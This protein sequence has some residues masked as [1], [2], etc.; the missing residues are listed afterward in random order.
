MARTLCLIGYALFIIVNGLQFI[1]S[2]KEYFMTQKTRMFVTLALT[3]VFGFL[4]VTGA[5]SSEQYIPIYTM[6]VTFYFTSSSERGD[7]NGSNNFD[8]K[9]R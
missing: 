7:K 8:D 4:A 3:I 9:K 5:I 6:I 2:R 1:F